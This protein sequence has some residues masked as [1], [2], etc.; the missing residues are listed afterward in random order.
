MSNAVIVTPEGFLK[1]WLGHRALTRRVIE[2]FPEDQLFTFSAA[3]PMRPFGAL[4]W[5]IQQVSEMTLDGLLT[6]E[7]AQPDWR[8]G[9]STDRAKLLRDWD[10]LSERLEKE[11][12]KID[13][14]FFAQNHALPWGEMSGWD[15]AI[16]NID[17]KIHHRG[18]GYVY[19]RALGIEPPAFWE[20]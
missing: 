1:H 5:E 19:L 15:A 4:A 8:E 17:N 11:F 9:T 2:A 12:S 10:A 14:K 3:E 20:R 13:L 18:Q 16:Y 6:G 7:W